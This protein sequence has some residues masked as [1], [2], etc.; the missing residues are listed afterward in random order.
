MKLKWKIEVK[1]IETATG[2]SG[3]VLLPG[4]RVTS[5]VP[6]ARPLS[7]QRA[8]LIHQTLAADLP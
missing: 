4:S 1:T 3:K 5:L 7:V 8:E 6:F 2:V